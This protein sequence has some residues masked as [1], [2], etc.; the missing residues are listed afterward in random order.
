MSSK[1]KNRREQ[2]SS[3]LPTDTQEQSGLTLEEANRDIYEL[4]DLQSTRATRIVAKSIALDAIMPNATQ[5]RRAVPSGVRDAAPRGDVSAMFNAWVA[6][7]ALDHDVVTVLLDGEETE[8]IPEDVDAVTAA[9]L[10][11]I[12]VAGSIKRDGLTNPITLTKHGDQYEIE[13]GERRWLAYHLLNL[14]YAEDGWDVIPARVMDGFSVWRQATE[15]TA[16]DDL[17]AIAKARQLA[18][19]LMDLHLQ[20]GARFQPI[21]NFEHEQEFYAQAAVLNVPYGK[22][23][24]LLSAMGVTHKSATTRY[25]SMLRLPV[26]IWTL[27]DDLD[28]NLTDLYAMAQTAEKSPKDALQMACVLAASQ[29]VTVAWC[30]HSDDETPKAKRQ[31][32]LFTK[33]ADQ[34]IPSIERTI[35][36]LKG[37]DRKKAI[38]YLRELLDK[39]EN[40]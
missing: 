34:Q 10:K 18:L 7:S 13:T 9:L 4:D 39:L 35:R 8:L 38:G 36:K 17:N 28:W 21:T 6:Q 29:G 1:R 32:S 33:F 27:A 26:E 19:L 37:R 11:V 15:N 30:N 23:S 12:D 20:D 5:P 3:W 40:E 14:I 24:V 16:R 2:G 22:G 31:P 25:R